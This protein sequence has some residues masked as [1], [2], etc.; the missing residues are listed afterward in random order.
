MQKLLAVTAILALLAVP[1]MAVAAPAETAFAKPGQEQHWEKAAE[2]MGLTPEQ[3]RE[4]L[5]QARELKLRSRAHHKG[6]TYEEL[7]EQLEQRIRQGKGKWDKGCPQG[8]E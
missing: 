1:A 4:I 3:A 5:E 8:Q 6:V 7:L 2:E